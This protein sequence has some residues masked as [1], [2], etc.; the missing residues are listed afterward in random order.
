MEKVIY[1]VR[2][3]ESEGNLGQV[4]QGSKSPLTKKGKEQAKNIAERVKEL[5][6][7]VFI[8][9]SMER[10][11][12]T[13]EIIS[14]YI[15][16][17]FELADLFVERQKPSSVINLLK[18]DKEAQKIMGKWEESL[19]SNGTRVGDGENFDDLKLRA[20]KTLSFL[21]ERSESN[22]LVV[23][24]GFFLRILFAYVIFGSELDGKIFELFARRLQASN[25][26]ITVFSYDG[27]K[28]HSWQI[29][30]WNDHS[31]LG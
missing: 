21:A 3:G 18:N 7:E 24:H 17:Q 9:S 16:K 11:H 15:N 27:D 6:I 30:V 12:Q 26:G 29:V 22:I 28:L 8:S 19:F 14:S 5:P 25:T 23:T 1:F 2:H 20:E 4:Y 13:S 10:A 31:H